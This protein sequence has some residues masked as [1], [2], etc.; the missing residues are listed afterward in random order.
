MGR[1]D[2][3][4]AIRTKRLPTHRQHVNDNRTVNS[5]VRP[6]GWSGQWPPHARPAWHREVTLEYQESLVSS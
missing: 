4:D 3:P 5:P 1:H 2:A 6:A